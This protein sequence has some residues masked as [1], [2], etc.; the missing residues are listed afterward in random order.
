M[1]RFM[2]F[3]RDCYYPAGGWQD[4]EGDFDTVEDAR[5]HILAQEYRRDAYDLIDV[6]TKEDHWKE[7]NL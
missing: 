6:D 7:L 5:A 1:K 2:L 3:G 4:F